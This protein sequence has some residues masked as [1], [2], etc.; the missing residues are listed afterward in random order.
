MTYSDSTYYS[1]CSMEDEIR[2]HLQIGA[3]GKKKKDT[4]KDVANKKENVRI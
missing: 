3:A 1:F 2:H 4:P